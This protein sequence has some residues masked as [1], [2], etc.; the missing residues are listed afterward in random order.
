MPVSADTL[1]LQLDYSA[2]ASQRLLDAAAKLPPEELTRD[3]K[4][5][6][7][8]VLDTLVHVFAADRVWLSRVLA[9]P[10]ATF[11]DPED[12]DL[13]VL[14]S[15]W[16]ALQQRWKLWLRDFG[17]GDVAR[18]IFYHDTR[19]NPYTTPVW[20]IVLHVVNHGT[21]HRGQVSGFLRTM[22]HTPPPLDLIAYYRTL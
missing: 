12:R 8:S 9:E 18:Q 10:R 20:Q 19:G 1:R 22:G 5:A 13:T 2:W 7:K 21:H 14:Q 15:E 3:F 17:D 11:V 16:P 4:T 6:D